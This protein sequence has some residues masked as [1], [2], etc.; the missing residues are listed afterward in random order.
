VAYFC[1]PPCTYLSKQASSFF[2]KEL[3]NAEHTVARPRQD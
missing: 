2:I 1:E 3:T